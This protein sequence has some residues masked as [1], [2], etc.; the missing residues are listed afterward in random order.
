MLKAAESTYNATRLPW[1][2][3]KVSLELDPPDKQKD[4]IP[5]LGD[6]IDLVVL[7]AGW[8]IDRARELRGQYP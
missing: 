7:G 8:D 5:N 2:K 6:C 3:L 1:A 4:Y